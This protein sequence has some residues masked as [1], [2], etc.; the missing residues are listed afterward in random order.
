M[1]VLNTNQLKS[2]LEKLCLVVSKRG[3]LPVLENLRW[4]SVNGHLELTT[5]DL[6]NSL[7]IRLPAPAG[8]DKV[9]VLVPAKELY[10]LVKTESAP[11][12][13]VRIH[14]SKFEVNA[15]KRTVVLPSSPPK[16]FPEIPDGELHARGKLLASAVAAALEKALFC[17]S[18][19][20]SR[21]NTDVLKLELRGSIFRVVGTDGHRLSLVEG[22]AQNEDANAA[23]SIL[24]PRSTA[25]VL[26]RLQ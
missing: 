26:K 5:T 19:E 2:A 15:S 8:H 10:Q 25:A 9:D 12:L 7:Q 23:F 14:D 13:E 22:A 18:A 20:S 11:N 1:S 24:L 16:N 6:D 3:S 21:Y 4:R 17:V